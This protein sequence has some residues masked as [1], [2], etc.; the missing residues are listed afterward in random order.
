MDI[1]GEPVALKI[2]R[3]HYMTICGQRM[4]SHLCDY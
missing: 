3:E 2:W 4:W 1:V